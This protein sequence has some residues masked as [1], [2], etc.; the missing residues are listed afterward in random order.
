MNIKTI[1]K[2]T[3]VDLVEERIIEVINE[4]NLQ[5]GDSL[6]GEL[7]FAEKLKVSRN[8]VREA[9]SRLRMLGLL[10]SRKK[11]GIILSHGNIINGFERILSIPV[12]SKDTEHE[13]FQLRLIIELGIIDF[14]F[15]KKTKEDIEELEKIVIREEK[16]ARNKKISV[17]C[18][19]KFHTKLYQITQNKTLENFQNLLNTFFKVA[20]G[21]RFQANRFKMPDKITHRKLLD[22]LKNGTLKSYRKLMHNHLQIH[23]DKPI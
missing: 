19:I 2:Q 17:E 12:F 14:V 15:L 13:L 20:K 6:P 4:S 3:L 16:Y 18:D 10:E 22:E 11:R 7:D 1:K 21:K 23:I 8:V 9:F 5:P